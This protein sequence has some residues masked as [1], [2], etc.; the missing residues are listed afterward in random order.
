MSLK[1]ITVPY[2]NVE[3]AIMLMNPW[4]KTYCKSLAKIDP[5]LVP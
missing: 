1:Q 5:F 4:A 2:T 3:K